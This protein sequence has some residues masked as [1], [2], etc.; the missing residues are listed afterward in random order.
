MSYVWIQIFFSPLVS[1]QLILIAE[2]VWI[3]F[4]LV[5]TVRTAAGRR[6][7]V[8]AGRTGERRVIR[9][10]IATS[11]GASCRGTGYLVELVLVGEEMRGRIE[12]PAFQ[13]IVD[14]RL[15]RAWNVQ[16]D[17][18]HRQRVAGEHLLHLPGHVAHLR[19]VSGRGRCWA[20]TEHRIDVGDL[21]RKVGQ[22]WDVAGSWKVETTLFL[23]LNDFRGQHN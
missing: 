21:D 15:H 2:N 14:G 13:D 3:P 17:Y 1:Q 11:G 20:D 9:S 12:Q 10:W 5:A 6:Q 7:R 4:N 8:I 23:N 16:I 19:R 18:D 22:P